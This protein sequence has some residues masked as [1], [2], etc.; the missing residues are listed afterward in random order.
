MLYT[1]ILNNL[2]ISNAAVSGYNL[3]MS[4]IRRFIIS[5]CLIILVIITGTTGYSLIEGWSLT[6]SLYMTFISMS[7]VGY[8]EV[9]PLSAEGMRFTIF[10]LFISIITVAYTATSLISF[11]FEGQMLH[12]M[13]ERKMKRILSLIKDH[14][15]ICGFGDVGRETALEFIR[16]NQNFIIVD[17]HLE[18]S[19]RE[20][21]SSYLFIKG[22]A[23]EEDTLEEARIYKAKG[24][25][26]CLPDDQQNVFIV[27][28]ARQMNPEMK[29]V[30]QAAE[31]KT[32]SKLEKAG[33][34][35]VISPKRIA[36]R[37][38]AS[39]SVQPSIVNFLDVLSSGGEESMRIESLK[40]PHDSSL[41]GKT[42]RE[43]NIGQFTGAIIIGIMGPE[44]KTRVN[45]SEMAAI[46][47]ITLQ[48][49]DELITLGNEEQLSSLNKFAGMK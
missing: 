33:A 15:I 21:F 41:I 29:I 4:P 16:K 46:S 45:P 12:T 36:G 42:L 37:R 22:D 28:T 49:G 40:I 10:F 35:R 26:C 47:S 31:E 20:K 3:L 30:A 38:M 9:H 48:E 34:D 39:L 8:G 1:E 27:L 24:L 6:D 17:K 43:T 44:G 32:V 2:D 18:D 19:D 13:K 11:I 23:T 14:Y 5:V 7:T 25:I